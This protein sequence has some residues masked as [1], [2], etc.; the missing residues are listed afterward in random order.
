MRTVSAEVEQKD[1]LF[2]HQLPPLHPLHN[3]LLST[4]QHTDT[5]S[6][7]RAHTNKQTQ[8]AQQSRVG[9]NQTENKLK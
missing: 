1:N 7:T 8:T 3:S 9:R 2:H 6:R 4:A 5:H